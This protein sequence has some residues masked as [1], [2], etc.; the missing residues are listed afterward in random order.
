MPIDDP[1]DLFVMLLSDLRRGAER[2]MN[3]FSELS[4]GAQ[5]PKVKDVLEARLLL[6]DKIL[7]SLDECFKLIGT[8]PAN[9]NRSLRDVLIEDFREDLSQTRSTEAQ[10]LLIFAKASYLIHFRIAEYVAAIFPPGARDTRGSSVGV[11][12]DSR[13]PAA[14]SL[15]STRRSTLPDKL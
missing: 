10:R 5:D 3:I 15:G 7:A 12:Q 6:S 14:D 4:E 2:T 8:T 11:T 1:R 13:Y 9:H